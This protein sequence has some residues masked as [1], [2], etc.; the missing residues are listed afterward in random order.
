MEIL[1]KGLDSYQLKLIA[2]ILMTFD[3]TEQA[4]KGIIGTPLW[5][6]ILGRLVAPIFVF[7]LAQGM[8]YTRDRVKYISRLYIASVLMNIGNIFINKFTP[9]AMGYT[10]SNN[11]FA[12]MFLIAFFIYCGGKIKENIKGKNY[13]RGLL[14]IGLLLIPLIINIILIISKLPDSSLIVKVV[15]NFIPLFLFV[16]GGPFIVLLGIG[17][18]IFRKSKFKIA[19]FYILYVFVFFSIGGI[20]DP[21]WTFWRIFDDIQWFMIFAVIPILM[22][23]N[24]KGKG[25]KAAKY[26][27]YIYYPAHIYILTWIGILVSY[28][29]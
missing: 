1:K 4:F 19:I 16:E 27:F 6:N 14:Y 12:S 9:Q 29:K 25:G 23:N 11:I 10:V 28:L 24:K 18:Y 8:H 22:Y 17:F 7:M 5:F 26:L 21:T 13:T 15:T 2:L 3:H 20:F